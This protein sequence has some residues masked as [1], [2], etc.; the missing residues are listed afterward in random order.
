[1]GSAIHSECHLIFFFLFLSKEWTAENV[2][3]RQKTRKKL[4][5]NERERERERGREED[6]ENS[7]RVPSNK[8][9]N[10]NHPLGRIMTKT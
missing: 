1:M 6:D 7:R 3:I 8:I 2:L 5:Y 4:N 9:V 10:N